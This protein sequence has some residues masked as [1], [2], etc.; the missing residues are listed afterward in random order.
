MPIKLVLAAALTLIAIALVVTLSHAPATSTLARSVPPESKL[1][2]TNL[3]A[4]A[5]QR[6]EALPSD[7]S[8]I[9]VGLFAVSPPE[10]SVQ[11]YAGSRHVTQGTLHPGWEGGGATVPVHMVPYAVAPVEV[12]FEL[13]RVVGTVQMLGRTTPAVDATL[14]EGKPLPGRVS[15]EYVQSGH[16]S[17][18]SRAGG[19]VRRMGLGHAASGSWDALLVFVLAATVL[20]LSSW[21]V[22]RELR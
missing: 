17:W 13:G 9:R 16:G 1:V 14:S 8:A 5:C 21:L 3:D 15:I 6:G 10:V 19:I 4:R 18:W 12:C 22:T 2:F 11:V 7:T 20:A